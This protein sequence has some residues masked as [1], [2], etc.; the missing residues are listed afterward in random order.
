MRY[1]VTTSVLVAFLGACAPVQPDDAEF[2][3]GTAVRPATG[4]AAPVPETIKP[5]DIDASSGATPEPGTPATVNETITVDL[6]DGAAKTAEKKPVILP[7]GDGSISN[8]QDFTVV[9]SKETI[10]SDA[11]KLEALK[12][13]YKVVQPGAAPRRSSDVNLA[14][15]AL[16]Q[17]NPVGQKAYS[18]FGIA[19]GRKAERKCAAYTTADDAQADFLQRGGPQ[20]DGIGLDPDGDGYACSWSPATYK[21][22]LGLQ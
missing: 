13:Q 19:G 20:K 2:A 17:T 16:A 1:L 14:E 4:T 21:A 11:A 10:E 3:G 9:T 22:L 18:R 12:S 7:E 15:F 6:T 5:V 8:S